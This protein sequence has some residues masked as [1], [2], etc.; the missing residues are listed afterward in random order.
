LPLPDPLPVLD[1][2]TDA[3]AQFGYE[4]EAEPVAWGR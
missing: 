3:C 4:P 2:L 1:I